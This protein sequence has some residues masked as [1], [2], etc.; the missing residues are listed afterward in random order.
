MRA[1]HQQTSLYFPMLITELCRQPRVPRD[2]KKDVEV[3]PTSSTVIRH[4]EAK[5]LKDEAKKKRAASMD[6]S[7]AVDIETLP[8]DAILPTPAT[9]LSGISRFT[10][11]MTPR[12]STTPL[13]P[14]FA[15]STQ[16]P[17][18]HSPR[19]CCYGWGTYPIFLICVPP[20]KKL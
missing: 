8:T 1:R 4:I 9:G 12:S 16:H 19:L 7:P 6:T 17:N 13:H 18:L 15:S 3:I 2:E 20:S 14:R 5:Y 11:F 10:P